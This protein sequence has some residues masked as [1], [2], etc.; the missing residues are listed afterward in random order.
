MVCL[1]E[2]CHLHVRLKCV[3]SPAQ[4]WFHGLSFCAG[5][6]GWV[7][8]ACQV[9]DSGCMLDEGTLIG[10]LGVAQLRHTSFAKPGFNK[11]TAWQL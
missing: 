9:D 7:D 1:A 3:W 11:C 2:W 5:V 6:L 8:T 10:W 4:L